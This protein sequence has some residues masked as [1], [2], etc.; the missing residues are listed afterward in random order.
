MI[1]CCFLDFEI[2]EPEAIDW[3]LGE[4]V[5][6]DESPPYEGDYIVTPKA[7]DETV[8]PTKHKSM[9]DD[10]T[11]LEIPYQETSNTHGTTVVI[12]S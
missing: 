6:I 7:F 3:D 2:I 4:I 12:A 10:V 11:V 1:N 9:R 5:V 8:L